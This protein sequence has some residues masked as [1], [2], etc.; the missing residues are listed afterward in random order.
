MS[1]GTGGSGGGGP[2]ASGQRTGE[3]T[4]AVDRWIGL[5]LGAIYACALFAT[6]RPIGLARDE[7]F[8]AVA[9][10]VYGRWLRI[11]M[12]DPAR[13]VSRAV[14]D[15]HWA[16]NHEHPPFIK[17]LF[18]ISF[19]QLHRKWGLLGVAE[20]V[21]APSIVIAG[22]LV[23]LVYVWG[24]RVAGRF[25]GFVAAV[26]LAAMPRVFF[27]AHLACFDI[28]VTAVF[29]ATVYAFVR[30]AE[31]P[32][33]GRIAWCALLFGVALASKHNAWFLPPLFIASTALFALWLR[34]TG[35][36]V[37]AG[38]HGAALALLAS[39]IVGPL[40]M[41]AL[42]PWI[43]RDTLARLAEY[44][45]FHV[46]HEFYNMEFLGQNYFQPP[47]PRSYAPVMTAATVPTT[48]LVLALLGVV[49]RGRAASGVLLRRTPQMLA[50]HRAPLVWALA[51]AVC[52]APWLRDSTPIFGGTK[53]W[54]TAY[55][56]LAL[57]AG[58]GAESVRCAIERTWPALVPAMRRAIL[59]VVLAA[60]LLAP[61]IVATDRSRPFGTSS[62]VPLVGG[63]PGAA[64]LGLNRGFWGTQTGA[65]R[66]DARVGPDP[67]IFIH[68]TLGASWDIMHD[69]GWLRQDARRTPSLAQADLVLQHHEMHMQGQ[70]YQAWV[71]LGTTVPW[72][73]WEIDGV[74]V[75]FG[76][77]RA[78]PP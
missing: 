56:F 30:A 14:V 35:E 62:Y 40:V 54:M 74:P 26:S 16:T 23:A 63:A 77:V 48:T 59:T 57:F 24:T 70:E 31:A 28:P 39:M 20:S 50:A 32:T 7:G 3:R 65:L 76:F 64:T 51:V 15:A 58:V 78:L 73:I 71:A 25:A 2:T 36:R 68:D 75:M 8:Y 45:A 67:R 37:K 33:R 43:W 47:F 1:G 27:H 61:S 19:E 53:H 38:A 4:L 18:A 11:L 44:V 52:Y 5:G 22:L 21:R 10:Q 66:L 12:N 9:A 34:R 6:S 13:A 41:W 69:D 46:H 42:W 55:P 49:A 72:H 29:A 17:T 60:L